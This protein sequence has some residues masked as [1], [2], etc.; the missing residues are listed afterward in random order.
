MCAVF[1]V[2]C[3]SPGILTALDLSLE[4]ALTARVNG[5]GQFQQ[6]DWEGLLH[7]AHALSY[8]PRSF[9][10]CLAIFS[11]NL[12]IPGEVNGILN[13]VHIYEEVSL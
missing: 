10:P 8:S 11:R 4:R 5:S 12:R 9:N 6:P 13:T 1:I 3:I 2:V 7:S